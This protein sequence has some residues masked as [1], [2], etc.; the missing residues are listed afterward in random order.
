LQSTKVG[1]VATC[2]GVMSVPRSRR[3]IMAKT[4]SQIQQDVLREL[5][6]DPRVEET[7]VGVEVD[8]G[9]V[10]LTGTVS[11]W[12]KRMAAQDAAHRVAGVLDVANDVKVKLPGDLVRTDTEIAQAVRR[13]LEW[14][15][16]VPHER[17]RSTVSNGWVTLEGNVDSWTE[18]EDAERA[19]QNLVGVRGV[20]DTLTVLSAKPVLPER[21]R[22]AIENALERRA[23]HEAKRIKVEVTST[24]TVTLTGQVR[25]WAEKRATLGAARFAPGVRSVED[26]L[27]ID[28]WR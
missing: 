22:E 6:W 20:S 24:G 12:A 19:V 16:L 1:V 2:A 25:S 28:P 17:I 7:E 21:V 18:R 13:A 15:A 4:D 5:T 8:S 10:T 14:D 26:H 3:L 9:I 27:Q 11:S 23:E